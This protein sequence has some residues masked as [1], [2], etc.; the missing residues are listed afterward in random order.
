MWQLL[1]T[2]YN[3]MA[4]AAYIPVVICVLTVKREL[5]GTNDLRIETGRYEKLRGGGENLYL[6]LAE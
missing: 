6:F 5:E 1:M 3:L 2:I 4:W